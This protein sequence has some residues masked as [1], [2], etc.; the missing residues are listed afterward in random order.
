ML[1]GVVWGRRRN[2]NIYTSW[3]GL[4]SRM[5]VLAAWTTSS[6]CRR[7]VVFLFLD[8]KTHHPLPL[9]V[10]K[11]SFSIVYVLWPKVLPNALGPRTLLTVVTLHLALASHTHQVADFKRDWAPQPGRGVEKPIHAC[12]EAPTNWGGLLN[13]LQKDQNFSLSP[14]ISAPSFEQYS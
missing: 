7:V 3:N 8:E 2:R 6:S 13:Y 4:S 12:Q 11:N 9:V 1:R 5:F 10:A 14:I